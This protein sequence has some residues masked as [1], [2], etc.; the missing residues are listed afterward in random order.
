MTESLL[1]LSLNSP[2]IHAPTFDCDI[3]SCSHIPNP[4]HQDVT[5]GPNSELHTEPV[6][7]NYKLPPLSSIIPLP[8]CISCIPFPNHQNIWRN[9]TIW[10]MRPRLGLNYQDQYMKE[11]WGDSDPASTHNVENRYV[12]DCDSSLTPIMD[13]KPLPTQLSDKLFSP[14]TPCWP[15]I[16]H[17]TLDSE[18]SNQLMETIQ[19]QNKIS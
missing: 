6:N 16:F 9:R 19:M 13:W 8:G 18:T 14:L 11:N 7:D 17:L 1:Q 5:S 4:N 2:E 10:R 12:D 15:R 3:D